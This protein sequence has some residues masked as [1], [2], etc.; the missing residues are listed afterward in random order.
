MLPVDA[1]SWQDKRPHNMCKSCNRV[2][3]QKYYRT[4]RGTLKRLLTDGLRRARLRG[5]EASLTYADL[6][7]M[8][9]VQEGKCGYSGINME[10]EIPHSHWRMSLERVDNS[11]GYSKSNCVLVAAEFNTSDFSRGP[12]T[13]KAEIFGTAQWS[14]RKVWEVPQLQ[15]T[16]LQLNDLLNKCQP[17]RKERQQ[18][19]R[20]TRHLAEGLTVCASCQKALPTFDFY[21]GHSGIS[22][23]CKTCTRIW[24]HSYRASL[25]GAIA[26][27]LKNARRRSKIKVLEFS[28]TPGD[29]R[30]MLL[31][32]GGRCYYSGVPLQFERVHADWRM[33]LERLDNSKGYTIENCVLIAIEFNTPDHG[34]KAKDAT[35]VHGSSQ[36]SREKVWHVWGPEGS[37]LLD[38]FP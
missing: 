9:E 32:Q 15:L 2:S 20:L 26:T 3:A 7:D 29:M 8:L 10:V 5:W 35:L 6:L 4:L 36:W 34:S 11:C 14:S 16:K 23:Y 18:R 30:S 27:C 24:E 1:F 19:I 37:L 31:K 12:G 28:M 22:S 33:S 21:L 17:M 38:K 25:P 13:D